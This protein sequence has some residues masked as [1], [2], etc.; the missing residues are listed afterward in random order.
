MISPAQPSGGG[1]EGGAIGAAATLEPTP[2][3]PAE[4]RRAVA[5]LR[6]RIAPER[7]H[8]LQTVVTE[9]VTNGVR[10][11]PGR[12][13][14][15]QVWVDEERRVCGEVTEAGGGPWRGHPEALPPGE[16]GLGLEI[17]ETLTE[18]WGAAGSLAWFRLPPG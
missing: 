13:M 3:A 1:S 15:L 12:P 4:A 6:P 10:Y 9:L 2:E 5:P 18:E 17:V 8:D 7:L 16:G 11:G 14:A